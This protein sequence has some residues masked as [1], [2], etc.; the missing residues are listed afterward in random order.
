MV[1]SNKKVKFE[2]PMDKTFANGFA[3]ALEE[4]TDLGFSH[5][6]LKGKGLAKT[7]AGVVAGVEAEDKSEKYTLKRLQTV[8]NLLKAML[9]NGG[10]REFRDTNVA[11][12][13]LRRY[14]AKVEDGDEGEEEGEAE[15]E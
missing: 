5:G 9:G 15:S 1:K 4:M 14:A 6:A 12:E 13:L 3:S 11:F 10:F 7:V 2:D 8:E